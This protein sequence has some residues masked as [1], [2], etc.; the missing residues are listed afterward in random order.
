MIS[1]KKFWT[2][3]PYLRLAVLL[4]CAPELFS[5]GSFKPI[6]VSFLILA[7]LPLPLSVFGSTEGPG[8]SDISV[9]IDPVSVTV[10]LWLASFL[11]GVFGL[12][13]SLAGAK[14]K[15]G[16]T[17][18]GRFH[19]PYMLTCI[20]GVSIHFLHTFALSAPR[21]LLCRG[22]FRLFVI[23]CTLWYCWWLDSRTLC[24]LSTNNTHLSF[25]I[26]LWLLVKIN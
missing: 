7:W 4:V 15:G 17:W 6:K 20:W 1:T 18:W 14:R 10:R 13:R 23:L 19:L 3:C 21:S 8:R 5:S 25:L 2:V 12:A 11:R 26:Q 22:V 9:G 16:G 24:F